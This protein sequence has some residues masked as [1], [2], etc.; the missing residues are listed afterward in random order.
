[1]S[2]K[3]VIQILEHLELSGSL[4]SKLS[5]LS[6]FRP[7]LHSYAFIFYI[8]KTVTS[9]SDQVKDTL[10][11]I[12]REKKPSTWQES[13]PVMRRAL[14]RCATTRLKIE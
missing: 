9:W 2:C 5:L 14:Y 8:G 11:R 7:K 10:L 12:E 4:R 1:M 3:R 13:N 6:L